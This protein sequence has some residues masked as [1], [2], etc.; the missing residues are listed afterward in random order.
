MK[1]LGHLLWKT[2]LPSINIV[3]APNPLLLDHK[4]KIQIY[5]V[6]YTIKNLRIKTLEQG[7]TGF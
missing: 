3:C 1:I 6:K 7:W 2:P 5:G 4:C